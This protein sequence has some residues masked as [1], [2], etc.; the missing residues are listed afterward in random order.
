MTMGSPVVHV[1]DDDASMRTALERLLTLAGFKVKTYTSA[2]DFLLRP[3]DG[4]GCV[5]LDLR[6]PGPDG[7]ALHQALVDR[8]D[9]LPVIFMTGHGDVETSVRAMKAGA[10]DFLTKP[11]KKESLIEAVRIALERDRQNRDEMLRE[12]D[13]R[14]R[15]DALSEREREVFA[16]VVKGSPNKAIARD[17][18]MAERTV[19][20]HRANVMEKLGVA[21]LADLVR[22]AQNLGL[23]D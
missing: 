6:M 22:A 7:M 3:V 11:L 9:A 16:L 17:T 18:G 12:R 13:V 5:L 15:Y 19:K 10:V 1:V 2:G 20:K 14:S 23:R 21:T 8:G 4:P